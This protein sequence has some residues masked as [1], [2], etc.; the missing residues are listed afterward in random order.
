M[1]RRGMPCAFAT[2]VVILSAAVFQAERRISALTGQERQPNYTRPMS[3][4]P[5]QR[6]FAPNNLRRC[7]LMM[8]VCPTVHQRFYC[9]QQRSN[10]RLLYQT[11]NSRFA[12]LFFQLR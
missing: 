9:P 4:S 10:V 6:F 12:G 2:T 3:A 11:F 5:E 8:K 1:T 7:D